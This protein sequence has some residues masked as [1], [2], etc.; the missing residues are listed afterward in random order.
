M[1]FHPEPVDGWRI[2]AY[3]RTKRRHADTSASIGG[4]YVTVVA[5]LPNSLGRGR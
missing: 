5:R 1:L 4:E 3:V 2:P